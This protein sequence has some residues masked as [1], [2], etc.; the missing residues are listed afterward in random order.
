MRRSPRL[1]WVV[2]SGQRGQR[3]TAYQVLVAS[4]EDRLA[5]GPGRFVGQ[6]QGGQQR[7][8][9]H[10]LW[11]Q[12]PGLAAAL[13]LEGQGVGQGRQ[14]VGVERTGDVG[15]GLAEAG[16]LEGAIH[17]L[18]GHDAG[19]SVCRSRCSCRRRGSIG[20]S[21]PPPKRSGARRFMRTALG[22]YELH[23]NGE[24]VGDAYF[25]PGWS[26]YHQRAYYNTYDVTALVKHGRQRARGV[27]GG[28][29]VFGLYRVRPA[30]GHR[31]G[32]HR[33]LH[34]WQDA[35][36]D[37]AARNRVCGRLAADGS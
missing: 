9:G 30:D 28:W 36:A 31:D 37:G 23:L 22:I 16:G 29:L 32:G 10:R 8:D 4:D 35:G 1:S 13:L 3:Q 6:R 17:Q 20:R 11:R 25:A 2:E 5:E 21:S 33:P 19:A 15:H 12:G 26:D 18:P 24:R 34:L 27:G 14:G 7:N